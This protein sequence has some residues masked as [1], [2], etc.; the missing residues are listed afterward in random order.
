MYEDSIFESTIASN[1]MHS[2]Q[3]V[4]K[5]LLGSARKMQIGIDEEILYYSLGVSA[6]AFFA[7]PNSVLETGFFH[8]LL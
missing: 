1:L 6:L 8:K 4:S 3:N 2:M 7:G 5:K